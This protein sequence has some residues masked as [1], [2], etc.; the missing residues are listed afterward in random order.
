MSPSSSRFLAFR[1]LPPSAILLPTCVCRT[2]RPLATRHTGA[3]ARAPVVT[4]PFDETI[5][6]KVT[7]RR[8]ALPA[9]LVRPR[10]PRRGVVAS[11]TG[12][13]VPDGNNRP[14]RRVAT[15]RRPG[16]LGAG[17]PAPQAFGTGARPF[18]PCPTA[19]PRPAVVADVAAAVVGDTT[20]RDVAGDAPPRP[21]GVAASPR[22]TLVTANTGVGTPRP[23]VARKGP[24]TSPRTA[25]RVGLRLETPRTTRQRGRGTSRHVGLVG[26][27]PRPLVATAAVGRP[28][29][30]RGTHRPTTRHGR[31]DRGRPAV[32]PVVGLGRLAAS[33]PAAGVTWGPSRLALVGRPAPR[34]WSLGAGHVA[35]TGHRPPASGDP[36]APG[37]AGVGLREGLRLRRRGV[38]TA[39]RTASLLAVCFSMGRPSAWGRLTLD[40]PPGPYSLLLFFLGA[41][42]FLD[43]TS[44]CGGSSGGAFDVD[45]SVAEGS[46]CD[47]AVWGSFSYR[48]SCSSGPST[49]GTSVSTCADS[50]Y[51]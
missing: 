24:F 37:V 45:S 36:E 30:G 20:P 4:R 22:P 29:V 19:V 33:R 1:L 7:V 39:S 34:P 31:P 21:P 11:G 25:G 17:T 12:V 35:L 9:R 50:S 5:P 44:G 51:G 23:G 10:R 13:T 49:S 47:F 32:P 3:P 28:K 26:P 16:T 42:V 2:E 43:G 48:R 6:S 15:G 18:R 27:R 8:V 41:S 14:S 40:I 38:E 46:A